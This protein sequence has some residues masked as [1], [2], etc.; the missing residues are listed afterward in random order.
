MIAIST[1]TYDL[2]GHIVI[3]ESPETLYPQLKR[4]VSRTAT[5]DGKSTLSDMGYSDSDG[6]Y[7]VRLDNAAL[8]D[9]LEALIKTY[10]LLYLSTKQ[11]CFSGTIKNMN[12]SKTPM[13]FTFLIK[14]KIS[15]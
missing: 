2:N 7:L 3:S 14:E 1:P 12:M 10:P 13:E 9:D 4:R 8:K 15:G 11:G 5:L 6:T